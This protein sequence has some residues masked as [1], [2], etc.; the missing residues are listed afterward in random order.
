MT[1]DQ[2]LFLEEAAAAALKAAH[3]FPQMAACEAALESDYGRSVLAVQDRNLFGMKQHIHHIWGTHVLPTREFE[4]GT[5]ITTEASWVS[6][7]DW[8]SCFADRMATLNRLA[9]IFPNYWAALDAKD[10]ETY[11]TDVSKTWASDPNR[12]EKCIN[13]FHGMTGEW[14]TQA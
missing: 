9:S 1:S 12:A 4:H 3:V 13:I 14:D 10:A 11:V 8:A 6:Y 5:W 7:P 2:K